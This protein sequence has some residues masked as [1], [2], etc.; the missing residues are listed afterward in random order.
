[1]KFLI[2][3]SQGFTDYLKDK[4]KQFGGPKSQTTTHSD[5]KEHDPKIS[6]VFVIQGQRKKAEAINQTRVEAGLEKVFVVEVPYPAVKKPKQ[7]RHPTRAKISKLLEGGPLHGYAVYKKYLETFGEISMRLIYY[8]LNRGLETNL[9]EI[10]EV[11]QTKGNYS[12]G[13]QSMRKYYK[14]KLE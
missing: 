7:A 5:E 6:A 11:E 14:L 13:N 4:A 10:S 1:M 9:F 2:V 12:W 8:H 3:P